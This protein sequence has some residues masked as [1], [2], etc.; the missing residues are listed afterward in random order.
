[1]KYACSIIASVA[2]LT[3]CSSVSVRRDYDPAIDFSMMETYAWKHEAQPKTG[4]PRVDNDLLDERIRTAVESCLSAKGFH[5][6]DPAHADMLVVYFVEY[7]RRISGDA[8]T[9]GIGSGLYDGYG[10]LG[11][12]STLSDYDEGFLTIDIMDGTRDKTIWRG[13]G[14]RSTYEASS[15]EKVTEIVGDAVERILSDFPPQDG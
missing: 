15:P 2:L 12:H 14:R 6:A 10:G 9:F 7:K 11:Y 3:G 8:W 1:M 5:K 13:V 4:N